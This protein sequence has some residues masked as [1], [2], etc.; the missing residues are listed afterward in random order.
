MRLLNSLIL[1]PD[2]A[3]TNIGLFL[4]LKE[5]RELARPGLTS[6]SD[7]RRRCHQVPVRNSALTAPAEILLED[8]IRYDCSL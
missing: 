1:S 4:F 8:D 5:F 6:S 3:T 7:R 2:E